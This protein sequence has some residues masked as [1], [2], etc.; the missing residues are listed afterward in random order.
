MHPYLG[1]RNIPTNLNMATNTIDLDGEKQDVKVE[2]CDEDNKLK[3]TLSQ[4]T[5]EG[6]LNGNVF[7]GIV[8]KGQDASGKFTLTKVIISFLFSHNKHTYSFESCSETVLKL[9]RRAE[10]NAQIYEFDVLN[11]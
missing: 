2:K 7:S 8:S 4:Y 10:I 6:S 3:I 9:E 5:F 1:A 11:L